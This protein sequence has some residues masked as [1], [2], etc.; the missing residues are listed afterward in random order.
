MYMFLLILA[1]F[2]SET[3]S[4]DHEEALGVV[5]AGGPPPVHTNDIL[6][7]SPI[8]NHYHNTSN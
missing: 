3:E 4:T 8:K 7:P 1:F 5:G 6:Y 2:I